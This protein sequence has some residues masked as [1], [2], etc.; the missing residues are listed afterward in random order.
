M[1]S[2]LQITHAISLN[3]M[4]CL[5]LVEASKDIYIYIYI[6]IYMIMIFLP[7]LTLSPIS[8]GEVFGWNDRYYQDFAFWKAN[9]T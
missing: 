9:C 7:K 6:Y 8:V 2:R 4:L 5:S 1:S 3:L